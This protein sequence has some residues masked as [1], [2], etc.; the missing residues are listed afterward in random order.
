MFL[1]CYKKQR[2][3][4]RGE[5]LLSVNNSPLGAITNRV[6]LNV[7]NS[8]FNA[9]DD[10][11]QIGIETEKGIVVD[12]SSSNAMVKNSLFL[13]NLFY[14]SLNLFITFNIIISSKSMLSENDK[15]VAAEKLKS[16]TA[17]LESL[18]QQLES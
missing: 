8:T 18:L 17:D 10:M 4:K 15:K 2:I 9:S 5:T 12:L 13:L 16:M 7:N 6:T 1:L 14:F 11:L 3:P